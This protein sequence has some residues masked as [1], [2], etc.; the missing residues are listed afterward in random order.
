MQSKTFACTQCKKNY[1][2]KYNLTRHIEE[3]HT[4]D[5]LS[6]HQ[7]RFK[8]DLCE[9][10]LDKRHKARHMK[11]KHNGK[12]TEKQKEKPTCAQ[13]GITFYC[14]FNL[15]RHIA[16]FHVRNRTLAESIYEETI[17]E[18]ESD[19][20]ENCAFA[21]VGK[22]MLD[23]L[24]ESESDSPDL[25]N[26]K[27]GTT[28]KENKTE[29]EKEAANDREKE[30]DQKLKVLERATRACRLDTKAVDNLNGD[31]KRTWKQEME[32]LMGRFQDESEADESA[33]D[34]K[35]TFVKALNLRACT[36]MLT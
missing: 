29:I 27:E 30:F 23:I 12:T 21:G 4:L 9:E 3:K 26:G 8:C 16:G 33:V 22:D 31:I 20:S 18:S 25:G 2:R 14:Q 7:N 5:K 1:N 19:E 6:T 35:H 10:E 11:A 15:N 32:M 36:S 34:E 24:S 13:C 17:I 28:G